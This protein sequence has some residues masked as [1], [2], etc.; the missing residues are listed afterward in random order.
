MKPHTHARTDTRTHTLTAHIVSILVHFGLQLA[1]LC[2]PR[3]TWMFTPIVIK[4]RLKLSSDRKA[5][6][7]LSFSLASSRS[8]SLSLAVSLSLGKNKIPQ[9]LNIHSHLLSQTGCQVE[10]C[11]AKAQEKSFFFSG[12]TQRRTVVPAP[13]DRHS[14]AGN[15]LRETL[16]FSL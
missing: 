7:S 15:R 12:V 8:R 16:H 10:Q 4:T 9:P 2:F 14:C 3:S 6:A 1:L 5:V 13:S 11:H